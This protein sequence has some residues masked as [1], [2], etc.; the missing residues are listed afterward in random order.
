[1][2][3]GPA[4]GYVRHGL[5]RLGVKFAHVY[6]KDRA[7]L[8]RCYHPLDV[9][10]ITSREEGG[11]MALMESMASGIPVVSTRVGMAPDLIIDGVTGALVEGE[12]MDRLVTRALE[13]LALP[14]RGA[15]LRDA[16]R[17]AV[18]IADWSIVGRRHL[19][20]VYRPLL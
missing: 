6:A 11:P 13:L 7:E 20:E 16:A 2:L 4:R 15:A 14:D 8:A 5:E 1:M 18:K 19:E 3:T 10:F 9:Y 17:Q 12:D